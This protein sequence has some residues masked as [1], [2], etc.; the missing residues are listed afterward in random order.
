[1]YIP[2]SNDLFYCNGVPAVVVFCLTGNTADYLENRADVDRLRLVSLGV[3][4]ALSIGSAGFSSLCSFWVWPRSQ[5]PPQ[6]QHNAWVH[7]SGKPSNSYEGSDHVIIV[8]PVEHP[9]YDLH[10][11]P[12]HHRGLWFHPRNGHLTRHDVLRSPRAPPPL[13]QI[14]AGQRDPIYRGGHL[15]LGYGGVPGAVG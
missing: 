11:A 13:D 9:H 7:Q 12:K 3:P 8:S 1:V 2:K 6:L 15:R 5:V 10:P 4:P 14:R